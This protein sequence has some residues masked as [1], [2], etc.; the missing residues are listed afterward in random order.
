MGGRKN[1]MG[2]SEVEDM[3]GGRKK[4]QYKQKESTVECDVDE[5]G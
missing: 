4:V 3:H 5:V 2:Y 1:D